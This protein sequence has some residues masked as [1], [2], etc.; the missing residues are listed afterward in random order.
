MVLIRVR[1]PDLYIQFRV[2]GTFIEHMDRVSVRMRL[3]NF[4]PG[5]EHEPIPVQDFIG[6]FEREYNNAELRIYMGKTGHPLVII[7]KDPEDVRSVERL[8][9]SIAFNKQYY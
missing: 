4:I 6:T 8:L 3:F 1:K 9:L 7:L 5:H 2:E